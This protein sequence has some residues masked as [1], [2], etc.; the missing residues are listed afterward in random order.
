[1]EDKNGHLINE[2]GETIFDHRCTW[3]LAEIQAKQQEPIRSV[4]H[5]PQELQGGSAPHNTN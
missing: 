3:C 2:K 1:M 4:S 5:A